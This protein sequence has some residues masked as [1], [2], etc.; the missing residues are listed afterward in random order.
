MATRLPIIC[1]TLLVAAIAS[2][3]FAHDRCKDGTAPAGWKRPGG[4]CQISADLHGAL[5]FTH[6]GGSGG[7]FLVRHLNGAVYESWRYSD[8]TM[9]VVGAGQTIIEHDTGRK[10]PFGGP[11]YSP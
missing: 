2:P 1:A 9:V 3:A 5:P 7:P 8:G 4:Y 10:D 11:I 6:D